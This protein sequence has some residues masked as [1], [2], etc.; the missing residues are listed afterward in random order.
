MSEQSTNDD[1]QPVDSQGYEAVDSV[2]LED[3]SIDGEDDDEPE[4]EPD[5]PLPLSKPAA[6]KKKRAARGSPKSS[7]KPPGPKSQRK[8]LSLAPPPD[9]GHGLTMIL[10]GVGLVVI[11]A[12]SHMLS[13][14]SKG[15]LKPLAPVLD[16]LEAKRR[17]AQAAKVRA[18]CMQSPRA[19][20]CRQEAARRALD[21]D[22]H[23]EARRALALDADCQAEVRSL[24]MGAE[25]AARAGH[26]QDAIAQA[27]AIL[28]VEPKEP[29]A[30]YAMG[31]ALFAMGDAKGAAAA[32]QLAVEYGRGATASLLL[33]VVAY[34]KKDYDAA[35]RN[36][37]RMLDDDPRDVDALYNLALVASAQNKYREA[38]EGYARVLQLDPPNI[39]ARY[40]LGLLIHQHGATTEAKLH[41]TELEKTA[42][43]TH[44]MTQNLRLALATPPPPKNPDA[45]PN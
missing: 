10:A 21:A 24:A 15:D 4:S 31:H 41:L 18:Q 9:S 32:G 36:F 39:N 25:A 22:L 29:F 37:E 17:P 13:E 27:H 34:W 33:G 16:G 3:E 26:H 6:R 30:H 20:S 43:P 35:K 38:R 12:A 5:Q 45:G 28:E 44:E 40:N 7:R 23:E 19:C 11:S 1:E 42:G 8:P 2:A 14:Q